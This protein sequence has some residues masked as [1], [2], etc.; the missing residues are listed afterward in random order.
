MA[1]AHHNKIYIY[2]KH[3]LAEALTNTPK[4][5]EEIFMTS[6][7]DDSAIRAQVKKLGL[8]TS[9]LLPNKLP[10]EVDSQAAHQGIIG[11]L[12]FDRL[13]QPFTQFAENLKITP[14]TSL[15]LLG[16]LSDPQ[17]VGAVIR[18]A[19]AFGISAVLIPEHNQAQITGSVVKVSA[20]M[21]FRIPLVSVSNVNTSLRELKD[22]GFAVYGLEGGA[23]YTMPKEEFELPTIFV[24]GNES[25][26]IREKTRELCDKLIS[27]PISPNCESLNA[28]VSAAVAFYAWSAKHPKAVRSSK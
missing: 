18:S 2:G 25:E 26:G 3:A 23:K 11:V 27:I 10:K 22:R 7:F 1:P 6:T 9:V 21:V 14:D 19:A 17:N 15:I 12:S 24:L 5:I 20:G 28:G 16:E 8:A 13:I 4:V